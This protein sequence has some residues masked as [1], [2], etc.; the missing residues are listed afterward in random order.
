MNDLLL[1]HC[2]DNKSR[3]F[4]QRGSRKSTIH[5]LQKEIF[6]FF[7]QF[8]GGK[9]YRRPK[10]FGMVEINLECFLQK[11][12]PLHQ[13][14]R[15]YRALTCINA[16]D[17][18]LET[19]FRIFRLI[20]CQQKCLGY[21]YFRKQSS[22]KSTNFSEKTIDRTYRWRKIKRQKWKKNPENWSGYKSG[23][24]GNEKSRR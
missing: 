1:F 16:Q 12:L 20:F 24:G 19:S 6:N 11:K 17:E 5:F 8:F 10:T 9:S 14:F 2:V 18:K 3:A 13:W 4:K 15:S 7:C 23:T 22:M 21:R